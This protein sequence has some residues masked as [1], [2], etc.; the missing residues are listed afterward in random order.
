MPTKQEILEITDVEERLDQLTDYLSGEM[1]KVKMDR[2]IQGR[3]KKQ[4][5]QAQREYYLN[6]KIKAIQ[7][8]LGR[9]DRESEMDGLRRRLEEARLPVEVR[10]KARARARPPRG[11]AAR[12]RPRPRSR[13]ATSTG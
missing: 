6:E 12:C 2:E 13:A 7:K 3:V 4:M 11:H 10:S 9:G 1:D 8:E 5:E